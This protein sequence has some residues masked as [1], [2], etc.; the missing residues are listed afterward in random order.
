MVK[1]KSPT[2]LPN[3][4]LFLLIIFR[5]QHVHHEADQRSK[6]FPGHGY[7]EYTESIEAPEMFAFS[8]STSLELELVRLYN[9]DK[10]RKDLVVLHIRQVV[11]TG[12][13]VKVDLN[14]E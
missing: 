14:L 13:Y 10:N 12:V 2:D 3:G 5:V 4:T 1:V 8:D 7:G 6:D 11:S 9:Q